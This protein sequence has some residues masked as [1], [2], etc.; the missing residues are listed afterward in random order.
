MTDH[1]SIFKKWILLY[2]DRFYKWYAQ[3]NINL[4]I[5]INPVLK[6]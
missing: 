2:T 3:E 1:V 5:L 4:P 6:C